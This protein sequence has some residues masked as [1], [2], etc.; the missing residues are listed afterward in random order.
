MKRGE[1]Q[2]YRQQLKAPWA[3][4]R[5]HTRDRTTRAQTEA[6]TKGVRTQ[7]GLSKAAEA[8]EGV[9]APRQA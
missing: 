6:A 5:E 4:S 7:D 3:A 9:S 8:R 2:V 1:P